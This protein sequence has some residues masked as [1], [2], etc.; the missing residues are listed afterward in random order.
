MHK[1]E[2]N[3]AAVCAREGNNFRKRIRSALEI[4]CQPRRSMEIVDLN[5]RPYTGCQLT[6]KG[7]NEP[8]FRHFFSFKSNV[9]I[10]NKL[11]IF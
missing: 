8:K 1:L 6:V 2:D 11:N 7:D 4:L 9:F 3:K 5:F 10:K